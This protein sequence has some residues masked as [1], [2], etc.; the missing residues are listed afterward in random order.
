MSGT[1]S[2]T[3]G[4]ILPDI[5]EAPHEDDTISQSN[6]SLTTPLPQLIKQ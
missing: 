5:E 2:P 3:L 1:T 6:W 4:N